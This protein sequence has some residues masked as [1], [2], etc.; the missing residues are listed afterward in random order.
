MKNS[1]SFKAYVLSKGNGIPHKLLGGQVPQF[2]SGIG[3]RDLQRLLS[4]HE[5]LSK[6]LINVSQQR[7]LR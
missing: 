5:L 1:Y 4:Q 3:N 7:N 2:F 6:I